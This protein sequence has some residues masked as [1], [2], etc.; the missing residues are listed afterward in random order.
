VLLRLAYPGVTN[1]FAM[2]RLLPMSNRD[3]DV[4]IRALRHQITVLERQLGQERPRFH[5]SDRAFLAALLRQLPLDV[6]R[7]LRLL[8]RPNTCPALAPRP[9]RMPPLSPIP[10]Q[11]PG[12]TADRALD[13]RPG[14]APGAE[15]SQRHWH[16]CIE[17]KGALAVQRRERRDPQAPPRTDTNRTSEGLSVRVWA[18]DRRRL[19]RPDR[20]MQQCP[21]GRLSPYSSTVCPHHVDGAPADRAFKVLRHGWGNADL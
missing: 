15:E 3:K 12:P 8:V 16:C 6:L 21:W 7:R 13:S 14:A 17:A 20:S 10:A 2:L 11:A 5:P 19:G 1:A 9:A 4:E 18:Y